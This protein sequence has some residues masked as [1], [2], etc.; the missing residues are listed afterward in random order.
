MATGLSILFEYLS[1]KQGKKHTNWQVLNFD[2][3]SATNQLVYN[4]KE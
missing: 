1:N 3:P 2:K 4:I